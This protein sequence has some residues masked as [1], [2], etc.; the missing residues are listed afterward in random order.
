MNDDMHE[1][2]PDPLF[3]ADEHGFE[4]DIPEPDD[5]DVDRVEKGDLDIDT[6]ADVDLDIDLSE[7]E[8]DDDIDRPENDPGEVDRKAA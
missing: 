6:G 1:K 4:P 8:A 3:N 5:T 2:D 7:S